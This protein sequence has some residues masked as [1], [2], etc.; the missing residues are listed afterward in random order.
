VEHGMRL[1]APQSTVSAPRDHGA[2]PDWGSAD[3]PAPA[4]FTP[5][6]V[7][8]AIGPGIIGLGLAIGGGEWLLGPA[9]I[10]N[11]GAVL[12]WITT[13][14]VVCQVLLNSEMARYT[15]A[16][17]EPIVT[18][19]MRTRPG[20]A[21]WGTW[22]GACGFLQFGWP[23][24]A[25]ASATATAA[26]LLGRV[27]TADDAGL[28]KLLGYGTF[29]LCFVITLSSRKVERAIER[30]MWVMVG[31]IIAYLVAIDIATVEAANWTKVASGFLSFGTVPDGVDWLLLGA[32][33]AYS[34]L[35]GMGNAFITN[36]M[37][38]KGHG[39]SSTVGYI[40]SAR[41]E[42][43]PLSAQGN[44]FAITGAS[45]MAWRGWWKF[46][47]V[48]QVLIFGVGSL[49]GMALTSVLTL[50]FVPEGTATGGWAVANMQAEAIAAVHGR[51]FWYLTVVC[52]FWVLFST[53]LGLVDG[54]P[55]S[56]TDVLWSG[57]A[58]VRRWSGG[59]VRKVYYTALAAFAVWGAVALNLAQPLTLIVISANIGGVV[60]VC[61]SLH[62]IV[63]NR[64]FLPR[65]LR[66]PLW[67]EAALVL[68][69]AFYGLF[70]VMAALAVRS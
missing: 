60:T 63:V 58:A 53:Q 65:E 66:P 48:D 4:P 10:V 41:A 57:S 2:L 21:F 15:L 42:R 3:L 45:L 56:A 16:T 25:L 62:T 68:T 52:G 5:A 61:L 18:G 24:W 64:R 13:I 47:H 59:D 38:D 55:R 28:V 70:A 43:I 44:R 31:G 26:L 51:F 40:A 1:D 27:P 30:V 29:A 12:L 49:V 17:G 69:A 7:A 54:V 33:A 32:F 67:R 14:A 11:Y 6:N 36:W 46:V 23:G 19:F 9:V 22:Y 35:G 37:R 50:Q 20:P 8:R 34:G 39:M